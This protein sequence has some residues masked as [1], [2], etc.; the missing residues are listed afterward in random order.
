MGLIY[1]P[2]VNDQLWK[3]PWQMCKGKTD[4]ESSYDRSNLWVFGSGVTKKD[5]CLMLTKSVNLGTNP[6]P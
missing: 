1:S 2:M 6:G 3:N 4:D 5:D